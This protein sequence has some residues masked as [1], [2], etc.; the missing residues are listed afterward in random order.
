MRKQHDIQEFIAL[1]ERRCRAEVESDVATLETLLDDDY[2]YIHLSGKIDS[3]ASLL[4]SRAVIKFPAMKRK[5]LRVHVSDDLVVLNGFI[6]FQ[7]QS[8]G[9]PDLRTVEAYCTQAL[10]RRG[11][12]W[13]FIVHQ[14]TLFNM[15]TEVTKV[16][17]A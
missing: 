6:L 8:V 1:E 7:S 3:K 5:D 4:K 12:Q 13:K 14:V 17:E 11:D 9:S 15:T 2:V 10:A 16:L